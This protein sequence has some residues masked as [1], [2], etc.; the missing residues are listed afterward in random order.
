LEDRKS[1]EATLSSIKNLQQIHLQAASWLAYQNV[2]VDLMKLGSDR[3][4]LFL[5]SPSIIVCLLYRLANDSPTSGLTVVSRESKLASQIS[6]LDSGLQDTTVRQEYSE[7][8]AT[9]MHTRSRR[10][11]F[12]SDANYQRHRETDKN[13]SH[14]WLQ[15]LST[16]WP[17][18]A[19]R[20]SLPLCY[21]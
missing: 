10:L 18:A 12:V 6:H 19:A 16:M 2:E 15:S 8:M 20:R 11:Y 3:Q 9:R 5:I 7:N 14:Q 1:M 13:I 4:L 17:A 21:T